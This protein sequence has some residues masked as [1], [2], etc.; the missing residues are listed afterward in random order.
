ME[1]RGGYIEYVLQFSLAMFAGAASY[2]FDPSNLLT[3]SVL[4]L[5]PLL[6]GYTAYISRDGFR[7]SSLL[8]FIAL[9][10]AT[11][12]AF[13]A[14]VA[15]V[16][17]LGNVLVSVFANGESFKDYYGATSLP[18]LFTGIII[19]ASVYGLSMSD[20][21][22]QKQIENTTATAL[23]TAVESSLKET[24]IIS[25]QENANQEFLEQS[26]TA[27]VQ[28]TQ[29]YVLQ[30]LRNNTDV[31]F[32]ESQKL[33]LQEA[34]EGAAT[35]VP[36]KVASKSP[37]VPEPVQISDRVEG[38]VK[39]LMKPM[40]MIALIPIAALFF[41]TLQPLTGLLTAIAAKLFEL[42]E[43]QGAPL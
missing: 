42:L 28:A 1:L 21:G 43:R 14:L 17:A 2:F 37:D 39:N 6:F 13:S 26:S 11:L 34:F 35:D 22:M 30:D 33:A 29:I 36:N 41:Y 8:S 4:L 31:S 18:L 15:T 12:G 27:S 16:I 9:M 10:F 24:E 3:V 32:S 5:V 19:G 40:F 20:P 38:A 7:R 23:G 25:M